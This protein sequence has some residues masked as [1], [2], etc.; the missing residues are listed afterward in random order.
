MRIVGRGRA[1]DRVA[2]GVRGHGHHAH[3]VGQAAVDGLQV[4][5]V[6]GL[7]EQH[8]GDGLDQLRVGDGAVLGFV[9]G[10]ARL[11]VLYVF[12]AQAHDEVRN[13][14]AEQRVLCR[15]RCL[16]R[17]EFGDAGLFKLAGL[18]HEAVALGVDRRGAC[19]PR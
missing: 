1:V 13:G 16:Q 4:L 12:A 6:E 14:L 18:G 5:V 8:G 10:D 17:R 7:G 2:A 19:R 11:G 15:V 3:A 9:R